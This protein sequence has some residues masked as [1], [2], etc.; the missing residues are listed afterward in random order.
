MTQ[1]PQETAPEMQHARAEPVL[2]QRI[3]GGFLALFAGLTIL[4]ASAGYLAAIVMFVFCLRMAPGFDRS[5]TNRALISLI[6]IITVAALLQAIGHVIGIASEYLM[7][8]MRRLTRDEI[9]ARSSL[10][11]AADLGLV[12]SLL[13]ALFFVMALIAL[14]FTEAA[15]L[16]VLMVGCFYVTRSCKQKLPRKN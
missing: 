9:L 16:G 12:L 4:G 13:F 5:E 8:R 3:A 1:L 15:I 11:M 6:S 14:K 10:G 2:G 7:G